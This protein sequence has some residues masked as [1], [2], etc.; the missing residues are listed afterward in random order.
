M[1]NVKQYSV[2][3]YLPVFLLEGKTAIPTK[4]SRKERKMKKQF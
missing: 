1:S 2:V 3:N 4:I